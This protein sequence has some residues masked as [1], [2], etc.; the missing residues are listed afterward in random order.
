MA[1]RTTAVVAVSIA[2]TLTGSGGP[3]VASAWLPSWV[4]RFVNGAN[5]GTE[6]PAEVSSKRVHAASADNTK[7]KVKKLRRANREETAGSTTR[8][9]AATNVKRTQS[10]SCFTSAAAVRKVQPKAWPKWTRGPQGER[11]WYAGAKPAFAKRSERRAPSAAKPAFAKISERRAP[12][13]RRAPEPPSHAAPRPAS[14]A[15]ES[16]G[17]NSESV[18]QPWVLE[19]RWPGSFE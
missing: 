7:R 16:D 1:F 5:S 19:H 8:S 4:D 9:A 15:P 10:F 2:M 6:S 12:S 11:C 18:P 17:M 3:V 13:A 14:L